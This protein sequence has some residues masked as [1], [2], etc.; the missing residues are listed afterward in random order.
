MIFHA[1]VGKGGIM[2]FTNGHNDQFVT[3]DCVSGKRIF[4][5]RNSTKGNEG[6]KDSTFTLYSIIASFD[7]LERQGI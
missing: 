1:K 4:I 7:A 2:A 5:V 3:T 6:F